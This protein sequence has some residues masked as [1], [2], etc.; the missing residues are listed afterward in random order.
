MPKEIIKDPIK[1]NHFLFGYSG[2]KRTE[3]KNIY[4]EFLKIDKEIKYI[5]EPFCGTSA[6]SYFLS[7]INPKKY[8]YIL[9]D[10]NK[11]LIELY[12]TA[13]DELKLKDLVSHLNIMLIDLNKEKYQQIVKKNDFASWVFYHRVYGLRAGLFPTTKKILKNFNY[14]FTCPIINFLRTENIIFKNI[15]GIEILKEYNNKES[16]IF[17]DPPYLKECNDFYKD[18]KCNIY[19][20]LYNNNIKGFESKIILCL[21]ENWIIKLLFKDDIKNTYSKLY[22]ASKKNINHLIISNF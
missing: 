9:N 2:N 19:E 8:T 4:N 16:F 6:F 7:L 3:F 13:K 10:N 5:V 21:S 11:Y 17:I 18:T 1:Q 22:Q 15:D 14:M 20:Y 12:E